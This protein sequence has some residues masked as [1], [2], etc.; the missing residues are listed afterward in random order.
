LGLTAYFWNSSQR[1][2][3]NAIAHGEY[4]RAAVIASRLLEE[5][6]DDL[7][8]KAQA[9]VTALKAQVRRGWRR[10]GRVTSTAP[11]AC[12]RACPNSAFAMPIC[13]R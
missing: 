2:L 7:E 11:R 9:T 8:L 10:S 1:E 4:A 5:H 13:D 12:S 6:P 3:K